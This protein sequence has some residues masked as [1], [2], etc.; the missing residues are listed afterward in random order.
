[1]SSSLCSILLRANTRRLPCSYLVQQSQLISSNVNSPRFKQSEPPPISALQTQT[2]SSWFNEKMKS[3]Y[4][5]VSGGDR[6]SKKELRSA[7]FILCTYCT[8]GANIRD[9]IEFFDL[10]DTY[11]SWFIVTELHIWMISNRV[12]SIGNDGGEV[13]RDAMISALWHDCDSRL[14]NLAEMSSKDRKFVLN[15]LSQGF[16]VS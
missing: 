16:Q 7:G 15:D 8:N 14:K 10:P 9:F 6:V 1:M 12:M 13:I 11:F 2:S 5:T 4:K 3:I